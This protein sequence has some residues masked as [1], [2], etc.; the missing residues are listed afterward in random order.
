MDG[1]ATNRHTAEVDR[2][3]PIHLDDIVDALVAKPRRQSERNEESRRAA[4]LRGKHPDRSQVEMIE[5]IVRD[6]DRVDL[7]Q[8]PDRETGTHLALRTVERHR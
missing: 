6:D 8:L 7:R 3:P 1:D 5:M 4:G 2:L